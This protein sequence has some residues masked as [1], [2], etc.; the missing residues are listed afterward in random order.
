M[1]EE[2]KVRRKTEVTTAIRK[3]VD[4]IEFKN[5]INELY[6]VDLFTDE[7]LVIINEAFRYKGFDRHEVLVQLRDRT[8]DVKIAAQLVILCAL[9][10]PVRASKTKLLNNKTPVE[11]GIPASGQQGTINLSCQRITA[12]T[13]DL[14]A[15]Y[16]KRLN[17]PKRLIDHPLPG[18]LQFPSAGSIKLPDDLRAQHI[19]F[20]KRFSILIGGAFREDIYSQMVNNSYLD[21]NLKLF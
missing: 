9:Q 12:S 18:W 13:A 2:K 10:G 1:A 15:Y 14:A 20:S 11:L 7:E 19:D 17:T 3:V 4:P 8:G 5:W 6:K 21:Q 16:L